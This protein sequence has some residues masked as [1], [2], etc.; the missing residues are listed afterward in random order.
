MKRLTSVAELII[1]IV[2][3]T[4]ELVVVRCVTRAG[5]GS[6]SSLGRL[7]NTTLFHRRI[8]M[9]N[10]L[11]VTLQ[12]LLR[13]LIRWKKRR[14]LHKAASILNGN[15]LYDAYFCSLLDAETLAFIRGEQ[16]DS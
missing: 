9:E 3:F 14:A 1:R 13:V 16:H 7:L 4:V 6:S 8:V 11:M 2:V 12:P 15:Q 10:E 5:M